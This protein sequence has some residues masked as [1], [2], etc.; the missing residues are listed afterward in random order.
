M[1][2]WTKVLSAFV[3]ATVMSVGVASV[4]GCDGCDDKGEHVH[5]YATVWSSDKDGH[6]H[7]STCGHEPEA[8]QNHA[9]ADENGKCDVCDYDMGTQIPPVENKKISTVE[10]LV[11]FRQLGE[12][13]E[14]DYTLEADIDL[15][16]IELAAPTVVLSGTATFNGNGHFIQNAAYSNADAKTGL[17]FKSIKGGTVS[18]IKFLNCG[19]T[20]SNE[21]AGLL[22]GTVESGN[23]DDAANTKAVISKIEFN[24]CS[25]KSTG[26]YGALLY[27]TKQRLLP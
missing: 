24:S 19:V 21:S 7:E 27:R 6:W 2:K 5:T 16:G 3:V 18:N 4:A 10:Q 25:V 20:S 14:G 13:T 15:N 26:N 22:A 1:K 17:L 11:A 9:D 23:K 8:K 12:I